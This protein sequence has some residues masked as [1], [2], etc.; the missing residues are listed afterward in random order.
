MRPMWT[1]PPF[2][3][4]NLDARHICID[5][6]QHTHRAVLLRIA[7]GRGGVHVEASDRR[8]ILTSSADHHQLESWVNEL[9]DVRHHFHQSDGLAKALYKFH[10]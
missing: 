1:L 2:M 3:L 5:L 8:Y 9:C 7:R 4:F 6:F 10:G